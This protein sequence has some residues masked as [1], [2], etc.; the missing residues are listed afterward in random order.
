MSDR[1][2]AIAQVIRAAAATLGGDSAA[3]LD[4]EVLM[5][6]AL[7]ISRSEVLARGRDRLP[8]AK[9]TAFRALLRRRSQGEPLAYIIGRV[10]F[11]LIELEVTPDVL[12]PRPETE[13]LVE[14]ALGRAGKKSASDRQIVALDVGTGSGAIALALAAAAPTLTV[15]ATDVSPAALAV[16]RANLER[17]GLSSRV[18]LLQADLLPP[19]QTMFDIVV[20]NLPYVGT[21]DP[22]LDPMV[23]TYEPDIALYS[24]PDGL[25]AIGRLLRELPTRL[26]EGAD[27]GIEIGWRQASAV[28]ALARAAF[29]RRAVRVR[30]DLAG[31]D[32]L[33]TVDGP[34]CVEGL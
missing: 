24:G 26:A 11:H 6:H 21:R 17:L 1:T 29:P 28:A 10:A 15:W 34:E 16:A 7:G 5:S 2:P 4:A 20:A 23:A 19:G 3:E 13:L 22:D 33:V 8:P 30:Q 18:R 32:R 27:V 31:R 9:V 14:W 12:V 25:S